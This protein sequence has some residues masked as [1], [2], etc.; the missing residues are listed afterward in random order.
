MNQT[1]FLHIIDQTPLV[2]IDLIL[3]NSQGKVLLGYRNN[4]P[5]QGYWFVPGGRIRKNETLAQA[6]SRISEV[7]LGFSIA[8][9]DT[10]LLGA[11]DHI[12]EDNFQGTPE[13]N[14]HYVALGHEVIL[15]KMQLIEYDS[16]HAQVKWWSVAELLESTSV[17]QNTKAYFIEK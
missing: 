1:K 12:Y 15:E 2:S 13:V 9:E 4:K 17:H 14:T 10:R 6:M 11:Y 8:I 16:Q 5:A 7:E 3:K